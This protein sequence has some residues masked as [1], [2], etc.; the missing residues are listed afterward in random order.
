MPEPDDESKYCTVKTRYLVISI[1]GIIFSTIFS[2]F[3]YLFLF[4]GAE[5]S[6]KSGILAEQKRPEHNNIS[7][8]E[9]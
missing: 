1:I 5:M 6:N 9:S 4:Y 2:A 7:S 3:V 8:P